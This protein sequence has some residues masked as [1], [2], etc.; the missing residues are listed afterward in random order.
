[1][2]WANVYMFSEPTRFGVSA[3]QLRA[4]IDSLGPL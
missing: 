2:E 4:F 3:S 1:M